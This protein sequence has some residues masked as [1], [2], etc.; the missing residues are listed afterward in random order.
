MK[1]P[2]DSVFHFIGII[3]TGAAAVLGLMLFVTSGGLGV[4]LQTLG[5]LLIVY[6][7]AIFA[8]RW[9]KKKFDAWRQSRAGASNPD[10]GA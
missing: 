8:W 6:A 1:N 9:M 5:A 2:T 7:T 3:A 4:L 10:G